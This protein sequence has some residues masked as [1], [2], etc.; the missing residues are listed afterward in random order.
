MSLLLSWGPMLLLIGVWV[1]FMRQMQGGGKGGAFLL[2]QEQGAP[3]R[4]VTNSITFATSP[5]VTRPRRKSPS[6]STSCVI[7]RNSRSSVGGFRAACCWSATRYR[8]DAARQGHRRRGQGAVLL[9]FRFRFRRNVRR[10]RCGTRPRH[11]SRMPRKT[12]PASSSSTNW[13]AVGR[14]RGAGLAAAMTSASRR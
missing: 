12:P 1:F 14:Q 9:D 8:Q 10:C 5:A 2:R 3:A 11:V 13:N 7:R 4:R 6:S